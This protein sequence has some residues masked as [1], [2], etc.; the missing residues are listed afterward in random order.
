MY[1]QWGLTKLFISACSIDFGKYLRD[2]RNSLGRSLKEV[3][4]E[5]GV[6]YITLRRIENGETI[7]KFETLGYLSVA[8]K[9]DLLQDLR[10]YCNS[11]SLFS[12]YLRL[13]GLIVS[14]DMEILQ[15][16]M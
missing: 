15:N 8:Y 1:H 16:L 5:S 6:S 9:R 3:E 2:L 14:Y 11:N 4:S 7:P 10:D 13:E 12:Y